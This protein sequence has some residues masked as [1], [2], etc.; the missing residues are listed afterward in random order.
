[1][2]PTRRTLLAG[3]AVLATAPLAQPAF[4]QVE[5]R[6][7]RFIPQADVTILDPMNT[8]AT[9]TRNHGHMVWDT[10]YGLDGAMQPSPQLAAGHVVEDDGRRW[11]FT[12]RDGPTFH[13]GEPVRARDAVA[14]V[15]KWM[16]RDTL[17]QTLSERLDEI[18]ALDDRRFEMRLKRPFG[19][20]LDGLAKTASYPCFVYPERHATQDPNRALTEVVGSGPYRFVPEERVSGSQ[21]VYRRYDRYVPAPG[22]AVM[23]AGPKL[24]TF[25]R[26]EWKVIQDPATAAAA[27]QA[28]EVDWWEQVAPDLRPLL[29]RARNVVVDLI[30][31]AGTIPSLRPNHLHP[32]FDDPAVRRAL[33]ASIPQAEVMTS[34]M[35]DDRSLWTDGVGAFPKGSPLENDAGLSALTAPRNIEATR[36]ALA[37]TGKA[38]AKVVVLHPTDVANNNAMTIVIV[39]Y[40][41][42]IGFDAESAISDWG[43]VLQRRARKTPPD[44]GGW[45]AVIAIFNG[46]ELM[47]PGNNPLLRANG[48]GAWFGWPRSERLESLRD[49]WFDAPSLD[50]QRTIA[51]DI[52]TQF[53][54][55]VPHWP[56]G[57]Y[58]VASAYRRGLTG[59]RRGFTTPLNARRG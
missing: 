5:S 49:A 50:A 44:A 54:Q 17:G 52:Q 37:A 9:P 47:N 40:L 20:M 32:P 23:T 57:Q 13:D 7:L 45:N 18:R 59:I 19:P 27:L 43:T 1:M 53:F 21:L 42:R 36:R 6:V 10:L 51:R 55:D 41:R 58:Q 26:V 33:W 31:T 2:S 56:L 4:S 46:L 24:A 3:S 38:G 12:L 11:T 39:D 28:G 15:R 25:E 48:D 22:E 34:I 16:L 30:E 14:S 8:T 35:G 29:T